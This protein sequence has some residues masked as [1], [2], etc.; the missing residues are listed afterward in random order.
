MPD[1]TLKANLLIPETEKSKS[2]NTNNA[3]EDNTQGRNCQEFRLGTWRRRT[4][5]SKQPQRNYT[6]APRPS[7]LPARSARKRQA[8][9][10]LRRRSHH[11]DGVP[12]RRCCLRISKITYARPRDF[13]YLFA[14]RSPILEAFFFTA[15]VGLPSFAAILA[16]G[17]LGKSFLRRLRSLLVHTPLMALFFATACPLSS[18]KEI[19]YQKT[20]CKMKDVIIVKR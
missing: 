3:R 11:K 2:E 5:K 19:K 4:Q 8:S 14:L 17:L 10:R 7:Q 16:V 1:N 9:P 18:L 15:S 13:M 6:R 12:C 20:K